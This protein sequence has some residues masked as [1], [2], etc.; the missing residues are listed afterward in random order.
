[1]SIRSASDRG[2]T[3]SSLYRSGRAADA[4]RRI[5]SLRTIMRGGL[6]LDL[7]G[8]DAAGAPARRFDELTVA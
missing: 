3:S 4:L 7:S 5:A 6:G 8:S 2:T 1:M